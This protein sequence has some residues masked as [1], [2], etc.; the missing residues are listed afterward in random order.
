MKEPKF[1]IGDEIFFMHFSQPRKA[2]VI[3]VVKTE[4]DVDTTS[5]KQKTEPGEVAI[6]YSVG[7]FNLVEEKD[8]YSSKDE[9]INGV[10]SKI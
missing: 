7:M 9:L 3:G 5:F 8:A 2:K 6:L 1:K 10:F 4:G